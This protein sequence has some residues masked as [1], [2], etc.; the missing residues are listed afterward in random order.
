MVGAAIVASTWPDLYKWWTRQQK[1]LVEEVHQPPAPPAA[2]VGALE[3]QDW[4]HDDVLGEQFTRNVQFFGEASQRHI[5]NS[6]VVVIGLGGV[7]S[8][9]AHLLL[10]S[11]VGRLRLVDFDQVSL[12]SLNRHAVATR[13]D[14]GTSKAEC[15]REHFLEILPEGR[16]E[17][18]NAMYT[19][20]AEEQL[21]GGQPD[22]VLDAIDNI[23][24]KVALLAACRRRGI[25]V[26][27]SAG[28]GAKADPTRLRIAD[29]AECH[30]D[31]L[32]RAVRQH[33]KRKHGLESGIPVL[34]ST[35]RPRC[36]LV[37]VEAVGPTPLD[38]QV[39]PGFRVRTIPVLGTMPAIFGMAAASY[40]LCQLAGQPFTSEPLFQL[41]APQYQTQLDRLLEREEVAHGTTANVEVDI[42]DV[43][44]LVRELWRGVSAHQQGV[45][46]AGAN[47]GLHRS[48]ADLVLVRW[49]SQRPAAVD[50]LVLMTGHEADEH[51]GRDLH[52]AAELHPELAIYVD[53]M[54]QRAREEFGL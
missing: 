6:F 5:A 12:S 41:Q 21:L 42:D 1:Q 25:P 33:L 36:K 24:T 20:E 10:R 7:G 45:S 8:H 35:E 13:A 40:I 19:A 53:K 47:K 31:P 28:A 46:T 43:Q 18:V 16:V 9:A 54:L 22:F 14:V 17:A 50:N 49:D 4:L 30:V 52:Q 32:A 48:T 26:L 3:P 51:A 27:C 29:L 11:G 2:A 34:L 23:E 37:P 38:Y 44:Y 15:L 39:V